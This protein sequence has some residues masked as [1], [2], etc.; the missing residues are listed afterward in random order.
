MRATATAA[1]LLLAAGCAN[2]IAVRRPLRPEVVAE[3]NDVLGDNRATVVLASP[4]PSQ[5]ALVTLGS[6]TTVLNGAQRKE[7][8]TAAIRTIHVTR[9]GRGA[10]EGL[11]FGVLGGV[12]GGAV[13]G[14]AFATNLSCNDNPSCLYPLIGAGAG[15]VLGSMVGAFVGA[16]IGHRTTID[17]DPAPP[18]TTP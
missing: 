4:E 10:L 8:P 1:F 2:T 17:F 3:I 5:E 11:G 9:P 6:Q 7:V 13:I 12:L 18:A 14:A 16:S 15:A